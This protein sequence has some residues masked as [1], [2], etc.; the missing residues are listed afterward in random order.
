MLDQIA[1]F[2]RIRGHTVFLPGLSSSSLVV[3]AGSHRG[4]FSRRIHDLTGARCVLIEAHPDLAA[5]IEPPPGATVLSAAL[6]ATDGEQA[7][8]FS[9]NLEAG[10]IAKDADSAPS[11]KVRTVSLLSVLRECVA[12]RI[13]LLKLDIEGAEFDL[14]RDTP[15][16]IWSRI[17]QITIE[18][19]DFLPDFQRDGQLEEAVAR[20]RSLG[21]WMSNMAFKTHGD[22]LF[23]N[24]NRSCLSH[25]RFVVRSRAARWLL[26]GKE[27]AR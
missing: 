12:E 4:E 27:I 7:F 15:D 2:T 13:N 10:S 5:A 6:G 17:D 19:H 20:L 25:A 9:P 23:V 16:E 21:F 11:V 14:I 8:V 22:V 18:F 3:D 24:R 1:G 26:K